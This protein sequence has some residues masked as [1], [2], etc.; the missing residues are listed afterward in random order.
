[1]LFFLEVQ[2]PEKGNEFFW[3]KNFSSDN[4]QAVCGATGTSSLG[5]ASQDDMAVVQRVLGGAW[6]V[7]CWA[8]WQVPWEGHV[9]LV[10]GWQGRVAGWLGRG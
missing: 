8:C 3:G 2:L 5:E 9:I 10:G 4:S 6:L 7:R 1:M